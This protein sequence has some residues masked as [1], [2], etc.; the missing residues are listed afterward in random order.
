M[1]TRR[2]EELTFVQMRR[3]VRR[4]VKLSFKHYELR[5]KAEIFV[6]KTEPFESLLPLIKIK[7]LKKYFIRE[8]ILYELKKIKSCKDADLLVEV[9]SVYGSET[10]LG[11]YKRYL[12]ELQYFM[13]GIDNYEQTTCNLKKSLSYFQQPGKSDFIPEGL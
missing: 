4:Q 1:K 12:G 5:V 3:N 13:S 7:Y 9:F 2:R 6:P 8:E 11:E 10:Y